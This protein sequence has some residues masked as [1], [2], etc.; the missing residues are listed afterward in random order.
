MRPPERLHLRTGELASRAQRL[1]GERSIRMRSIVHRLASLLAIAALALALAAGTAPAAPTGAPNA[2][3]VTLDCGSAGTFD[4]VVNGNGQWTPGH[5]LSGNGVVVPLSFSEQTV[6]VRD[7]E[8][9][10][11]DEMTQ[12]ATTKGRARA[13]GRERVTCS[14]TATFEDDG[15]TITAAGSVTGFLAGSES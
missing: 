7:A 11:I 6:T 2:T 9:N 10:V 1:P 3:V 8:G 4:V 5:L 12:A 14:F 13:N 15:L